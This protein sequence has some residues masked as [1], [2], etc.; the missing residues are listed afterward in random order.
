MSEVPLYLALSKQTWDRHY[1][2]KSRA[3]STSPTSIYVCMYSIY[4]C[5]YFVSSP[6]VLGER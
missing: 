5:M 1:Q 6:I 2:F 4:V 3:S